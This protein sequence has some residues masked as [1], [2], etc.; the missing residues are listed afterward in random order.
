MKYLVL[1]L[2]DIEAYLNDE[3]KDQLEL[4][5]RTIGAGRERDGK[6]IDNVY[7]VINHDEPYADDVAMIM[8]KHGHYTPR[9]V[10]AGSVRQFDSWCTSK[11]RNRELYR[12]VYKPEHLIGYRDAVIYLVGTYWDN[13]AYL[14]DEYMMLIKRGALVYECQFKEGDH[15]SIKPLR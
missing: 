4:I 8:K 5:C 13:E 15:F 12:Y 14:S 3:Q 1:K 11:N 10:I 2:Q 6:P 7:M 9:L